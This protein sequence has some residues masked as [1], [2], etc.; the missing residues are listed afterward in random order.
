M[1]DK[2]KHKAT[3]TSKQAQVKRGRCIYVYVYIEIERDGT[4][5]IRYSI[6]MACSLQLHHANSALA[7]RRQQNIRVFLPA[8]AADKLRRVIFAVIVARRMRAKLVLNKR[9]T[10]RLII[11]HHGIVLRAARDII[12]PARTPSVQT[13]WIA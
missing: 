9:L 1:N 4:A 12:A 7:I 2:K 6:I 3:L 8:N 10:E 13:A 5:S 11:G